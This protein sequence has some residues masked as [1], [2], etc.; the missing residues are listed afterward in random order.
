MPLFLTVGNTG[1]VLKLTASSQM[2]G[3]FHLKLDVAYLVQLQTHSLWARIV[4]VCVHLCVKC[5]QNCVSSYL[6]SMQ[7]LRTYNITGVPAD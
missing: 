1:N 4:R 2:S 6:Q 3:D 5:H 7:L